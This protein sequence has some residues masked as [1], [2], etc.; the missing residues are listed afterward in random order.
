MQL[1]LRHLDVGRHRLPCPEC[2]KGPKDAA[3]AVEIRADGSAVWWCWRC[4]AHGGIRGD[5]VLTVHAGSRPNR[6]EPHAQERRESALAACRAIWK[7][8][9][10]IAGTPGAEY[11]RLRCCALPPADGDLRFHAALYC[12]ET[13]AELPALVARVSTVIGNKTIGIHR[14]WFRAGE[15]KAVKKMRLGAS[16]EPVCIRLWPDAAVTVGLGIAEGVETALAAAQAFTPMWSTIDAGL[17]AK[18]PLIPGLESLT[19]F[20]DYDERGLAAAKSTWERYMH[21]GRNANFLRPKRVGEDFND[22][23]IRKAQ[24]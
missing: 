2:D 9:Q 8:T 23:L 17:M 14:I 10:P 12:P 3:L 22:V 5:R 15:P 13:A 4:H 1:D 19:I 20:A 24:R 6:P 16:D 18:F 11:L 7:Q 21:A